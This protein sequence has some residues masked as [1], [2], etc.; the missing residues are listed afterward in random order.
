MQISKVQIPG[1]VMANVISD[2][3]SEMV[4]CYSTW[5][6]GCLLSGQLKI[7]SPQGYVR[8]DTMD[9]RRYTFA[10]SLVSS[11]QNLFFSPRCD[12]IY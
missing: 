6:R 10:L 4:E 7:H 2:A 3:Y 5:K 1:T 8:S 9:V 12:R 11:E